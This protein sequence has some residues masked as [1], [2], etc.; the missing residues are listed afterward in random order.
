MLAWFETKCR[1][2]ACATESK[3]GRSTKADIVEE[4][5]TAS[6]VGSPCDVR[7][8]VLFVAFVCWMLTGARYHCTLENMPYWHRWF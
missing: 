5:C 4:S 3:F 1:L 2:L 7:H 6:F 8:V